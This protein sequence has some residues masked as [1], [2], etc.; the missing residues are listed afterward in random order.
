MGKTVLDPS[1]VTGS[2]AV[3][4]TPIVEC[5]PHPAMTTAL[6]VKSRPAGDSN[7]C[8]GYAPGVTRKFLPR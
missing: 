7:I 6:A 3:E 5:L 1:S 2:L 4:E 8:L